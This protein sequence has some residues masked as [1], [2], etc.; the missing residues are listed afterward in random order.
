MPR[1]WTKE[2]KLRQR[3]LIQNWQPWTHSTG[4]KTLQGKARSSKNAMKWRDEPSDD[5]IV[6]QVIRDIWQEIRDLN[7]NK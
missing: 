5:E 7:Q 2:Q 3:Q 6:E 4:A 1:K